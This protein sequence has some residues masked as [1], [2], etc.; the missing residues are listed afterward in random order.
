LLSKQRSRR[1]G[2]ALAAKAW[3]Y[4]QDVVIGYGYRP[5]RALIWLIVLVTLTAAYIAAYPPRATS[6]SSRAQFEPIIYAFYA[7]VPVL[8]IGHPDPYPASAAG[9]WIIW[10]AQL[11]GIAFTA[12]DNAFGTVSDA[13]AAPADL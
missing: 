10:I 11:A 12:L 5:T 4:L 13:E 7:V 2:L 8:N 6:G 1:A 3:S 9:Q